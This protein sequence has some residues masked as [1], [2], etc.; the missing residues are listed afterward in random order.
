MWRLHRCQPPHSRDSASRARVRRPAEAGSS[1]PSRSSAGKIVITADVPL[2][3]ENLRHRVTSVGAAQHLLPLVGRAHHVVFGKAHPPCPPEVSWR[4]GNSR[5]AGT[6][7]SRRWT[8]FSYPEFGRFRGNL[9]ASMPTRARA[10]TR[11]CSAPDRQHA[12]AAAAKVA[13]DVITSSIRRTEPPPDRGGKAPMRVDGVRQVLEPCEAVPPCP[14]T[15]WTA[16]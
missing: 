13:P 3:D 1:L 14:A 15:G 9:N 4:R 12:S 2:A 5:K 8:W 10:I 6:C 7:R 11:T 16:T